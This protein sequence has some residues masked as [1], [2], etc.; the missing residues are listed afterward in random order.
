[1]HAEARSYSGGWC[2]SARCRACRCRRWRPRSWPC[3]PRRS[4]PVTQR[5][6][7]R[8]KRRRLA[9]VEPDELLHLRS[10]QR[11]SLTYTKSGRE[12]GAYVPSCTVSG[13]G[14]TQFPSPL[15]IATA[16]KTSLIRLVV[17]EPEV[18]ERVD[19]P[20]HA[21]DQDIVV[22]AR[23]EVLA[24]LVLPEDGLDEEVERAGVG[25]RSVEVDR[26]GGELGVEIRPGVGRAFLLPELLQLVG[27]CAGEPRIFRI[28]DDGQAVVGDFEFVP[29]DTVLGTA[30]DLVLFNS[31][32]GV[33]DVGFARAEALEPTTCSRDI[34]A[35][36]DV[37]RLPV[38]LLGDRLRSAVRRSTIRPTRSLP[39]AC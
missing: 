16:F 15:S 14:V 6:R 20:G 30:G 28:R 1:M 17:G 36:L 12:S 10:L 18:A 38:E 21:F 37:R 29:I 13:L 4:R 19:I 35:D 25:S 31:S 9:Q 24:D 23:R 3:P 5:S 11:L 27:G 2:R 34:D 33:L 7:L 32:R 8:R 26:V 39:R 22:L